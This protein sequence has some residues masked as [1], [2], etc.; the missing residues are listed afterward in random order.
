MSFRN[1]CLAAFLY[2]ADVSQTLRHVRSGS[3]GGAYF[4]NHKGTLQR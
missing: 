2:V 3:T 4:K 1:R